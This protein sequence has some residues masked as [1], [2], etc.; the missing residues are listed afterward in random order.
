MGYVRLHGSNWTTR[1]RAISQ[2]G[3]PPLTSELPDL[4]RRLCERVS[5]QLTLNE[6]KEGLRKGTLAFCL[7][8][9]HAEFSSEFLDDFSER[10]LKRDWREVT[11]SGFSRVP[12]LLD[13][14]EPTEDLVEDIYCHYGVDVSDLEGLPFWE[15]V[16][17][18]AGAAHKVPG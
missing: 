6:L 10:I 15:V 2:D 3:E 12:S 17:R 9:A 1:R 4:S 16:R 5:M 14:A 13:V 18:C 11:L 8:A 7:P